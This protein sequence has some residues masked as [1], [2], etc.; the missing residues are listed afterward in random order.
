MFVLLIDCYPKPIADRLLIAVRWPPIA[1]LFLSFL[2]EIRPT[3]HV[4]DAYH[5]D[6]A[7]PLRIDDAGMD[8]TLVIRGPV[9]NPAAGRGDAIDAAATSRTGL[10][11]R[12]PPRKPHATLARRGQMTRRDPQSRTILIVADHDDPSGLRRLAMDND[13]RASAQQRAKRDDVGM[14][15][16]H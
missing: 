7:I 1:A 15:G 11:A 14:T 6:H 3:I 8:D 10:A 4:V 12:R 9:K 16:A 5:D 13:G 2:S